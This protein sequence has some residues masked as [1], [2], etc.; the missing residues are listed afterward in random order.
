M[1][2]KQGHCVPYDLKP[3]DVER[4]F[5]VCEQLL[6]KA[7][8]EKISAQHVSK[9]EHSR[10]QGHVLHLVEPARCNIFLTNQRFDRREQQR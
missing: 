8:S 10:R 9:I 1:I 4:H 6:H 2:E 7:K 3:R 5:L